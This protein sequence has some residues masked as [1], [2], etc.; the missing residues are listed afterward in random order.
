MFIAFEGLDG[1]GQ[2]TQ[3]QLLAEN[4]EKT[5]KKTLVTKEPTRDT[6]TGKLIRDVL[7]G[8][9]FMSPQALQ[10]LF[11]ADRAE[12]LRTVIDPALK[13]NQI[14]ITDRYFFSTIAYGAL[15]VD[16]K[17]LKEFNRNFRVPDITFMLKL[18]PK[19]CLERIA[20]RGSETEL[21]EQN[22]KLVRVW[23]N[24]ERIAKEFTNIHIIDSDRPMQVVHTEI[25]KITSE[26]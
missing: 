22:E 25:W 23:K 26:I 24:Y 5:G 2:S 3:A 18:D 17:W 12:H 7:Q 9:I 21:F 6:P 4:L 10:L 11:A 15:D 20:S 13:N 1:S 8:R 16:W 19:I 14:V